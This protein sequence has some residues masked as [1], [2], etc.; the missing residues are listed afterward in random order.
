M[1]QCDSTYNCLWR[2]FSYCWGAKQPRHNNDHASDRQ[3]WKAYLGYDLEIQLHTTT[4]QSSCT[5]WQ[6]NFIPH[7]VLKSLTDGCPNTGPSAAQRWQH[8]RHVHRSNLGTV[9]QLGAISAPLADAAWY[10]PAPQSVPLQL[11]PSPLYRSFFLQH[12]PVAFCGILRANTVRMLT[13][14]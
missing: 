1:P 14:Q 13:E 9:I 5:N 12:W 10:R 6:E 7:P 2:Y 3:A 4:T 11:T 8:R